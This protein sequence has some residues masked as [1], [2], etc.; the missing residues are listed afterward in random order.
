MIR[1]HPDLAL[2]TV[3]IVC[4][5]TSAICAKLGLSWPETLGAIAALLTC[6]AIGFC[7]RTLKRSIP[8]LTLGG[9]AAAICGSARE[10]ARK[11]RRFIIRNSIFGISCRGWRD[12]VTTENPRNP[13]VRAGWRQKRTDY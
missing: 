2:A 1:Q 13:S 5:L 4:T 11:V 7:E 9:C 12:D 3:F 6:M 8:S 10:E